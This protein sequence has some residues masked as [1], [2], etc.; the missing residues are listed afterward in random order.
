MFQAWQPNSVVQ[1]VF[2]VLLT[3]L[4]VKGSIK[5]SYG[6]THAVVLY[7]RNNLLLPRRYAYFVCNKKDMWYHGF[8]GNNN[9]DKA[10]VTVFDREKSIDDE[11]RW[12]II[13]AKIILDM[14]H[15]KKNILPE[16]GSEKGQGPGLNKREVKSPAISAVEELVSHY[17]PKRGNY[18]F[19]FK[20][21]D[22]YNIYSLPKDL[23]QT[24]QRA[25]SQMGLSMQNKV[26]GVKPHRM[27]QEFVAVPRMSYIPHQEAASQYVAPLLP[28]V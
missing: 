6:I 21:E 2:V 27:I 1:L 8:Q 3:L 11:Y 18:M 24:S 28:V 22:G 19:K 5:K 26:R 12:K 9:I 17:V 20:N 4:N 23:I 7:E 14:L 13:K 16:I 10:R 25:E 15:L